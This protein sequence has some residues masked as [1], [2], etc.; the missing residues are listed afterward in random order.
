LTAK[1]LVAQI[2]N[3]EN[4]VN[5]PNLDL[6]METQSSFRR[7]TTA[8]LAKVKS[9]LR[10]ISIQTPEATFCRNRAKLTN[11]LCVTIPI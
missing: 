3:G 11:A 5:L 6:D 9:S 2:L 4:C 7:I 10:S 1:G 8:K